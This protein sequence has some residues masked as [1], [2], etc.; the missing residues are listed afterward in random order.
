[1]WF[2]VGA[3]PLAWV[4]QLLAGWMVDEARCGRASNDWGIDDT[5]WQALISSAA[6]VVAA[7]GVVAAFATW[8]AVRTGAGD[9]RGRDDFLAVT[10]LSAGLL[11]LLLTLVTAVGVLSQAPCRG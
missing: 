7:A 4:F 11:F 8:R 9:A 3:P 6:V 5:L 1:M 2:G 10:S